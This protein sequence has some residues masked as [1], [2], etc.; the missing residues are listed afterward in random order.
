[1]VLPLGSSSS[2]RSPQE[3]P[4]VKQLTYV[5]G[6]L[7][8]SLRPEPALKSC[9]KCKPTIPQ[10]ALKPI[11]SAGEKM[12]KGMKTYTIGIKVS[13]DNETSE[14]IPLLKPPLKSV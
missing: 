8:Q 13:R 7:L 1:M 10:V 4:K 2:S 5:L 9:D 6:M 3:I 12:E 11:K 14:L